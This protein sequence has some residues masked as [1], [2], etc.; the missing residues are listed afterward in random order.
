MMT[1]CVTSHFTLIESIRTS[2]QIRKD[3]RYAFVHVSR[4]GVIDKPLT[5]LWSFVIVAS[6]ADGAGGLLN[7]EEGILPDRQMS[8]FQL[9]EPSSWVE[10]VGKR[11]YGRVYQEIYGELTC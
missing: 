4:C 7:F 11:R 2:K 1:N 9:Y 8:P 5:S 3:N 10:T 6:G